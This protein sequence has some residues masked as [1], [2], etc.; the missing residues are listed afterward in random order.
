MIV[1]RHVLG[2]ALLAA[3]VTPA[4]AQL[5]AELRAGAAIGNHVPAAAGL[6]A[7][8]GLALA[9]SVEYMAVPL[10][11]VYASYVRAAF[12]C[13]DGF[14]TD[15]DVTVVTRGVGAGVRLHRERLPWLRAGVLI[16][17]AKVDADDRSGS[18]DAKLGFEVGAGWSV[19]LRDGVS[20]LPGLFF[21]SQSSDQR[22]TV[23]GADLGVNVR[24]PWRFGN[25]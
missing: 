14:C 20:L 3:A 15:R 4:E 19:E 11:S 8:P 1:C 6:Q 25:R 24:I 5:S 18:V 2:F 22:T 12:G 13:D 10:A 16:Y 17:D 7:K 23:L 9:G 21:R